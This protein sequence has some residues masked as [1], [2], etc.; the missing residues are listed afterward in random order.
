MAGSMAAVVALAA[1]VAGTL[2]I[3]ALTSARSA[4]VDQFDPAL[5]NTQ[6]LLGALLN[7][8]TAV[9]GF[10]ITGNPTFLEPDAQ[11]RLE[12]K[13]A[14]DNLRALASGAEW[15][16]LT[17]SLDTVVA[18]AEAWRTSY[19]DPT[20][21]AVQTSGA[22]AAN[23][24]PMGGKSQFDEVRQAL[25]A[26]RDQ[27]V[28]GRRSALDTFRSAANQLTVTAVAIA[29]AFVLLLIG[30]AVWI[31]RVIGAPISRLADS[32]RDV[33]GGDFER[34]LSET[35]PKEIVGLSRDVDSMRAR[36]LLDLQASQTLVGQL[37]KQAEELAR[38]N[39][40]L[41]QF[42]YV[43]SHDLQEPLRKVSGFCELLRTRYRGQL[44]E[45]ADQYIDFA[46]DGA[47]RMSRLISDLLAF[48]RVGRS[49]PTR[50]ELDCQALLDQALRNLATQISE[51]GAEVTHDALPTVRGEATL[52][53]TVF[54]NL[55]G[56]AIKFRGEQPPRVHVG[57]TRREEQ[58]EFRVSDNG[59]GID[60]AYAEKVFV[61]FQ[62]LHAKEE[63]PGTGIGLALCRKIIEY[64]DGAIWL[65]PDQAVGTAFCF[66]LPVLTADEE[67]PVS[68]TVDDCRLSATASGLS[69][70]VPERHAS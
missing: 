21:A 66:T 29:V 11:G 19:A 69:D 67:R 14:T 62:R 20:I 26:Q 5:L 55:I 53:I 57:V 15:T 22:R 50:Q 47:R 6:T 12:Q 59:I 28:T 24:D 17:A 52:L 25:D 42:A 7:Q 61:I 30:L 65:D 33:A 54:Q 1:L 68:P 4:V 23:V 49:Q 2:T 40:D 45:R 44:D 63:Y 3:A 27:L 51:T 46:V 39:R 8:E 16:S 31:A 58:W 37:N 10:V 9:R 64:H 43:A 13:A 48:S 18:K 41:E 36:I 70:T 38:S 34:V 35:G 60:P 56:N 32:V